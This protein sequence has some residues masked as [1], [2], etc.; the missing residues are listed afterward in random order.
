MQI[1]QM[2][3]DE[4]TPHPK[5]PRKHPEE[6]M[7]KLEES[8]YQ[9]GFNNPIL[10]SKDNMIIA[11]HARVLAAQ[12]LGMDEV[13]AIVLPLDGA[14]ADAYLI[15]DN[16]LCEMSQW[17][18]EL[19]LDMIDTIDAS[20]LDFKDVFFDA[21]EIDDLFNQI[22]TKDIVDD[23]FDV[24]QQLEDIVDPITQYGDIWRLGR[25]VLICGDSTELDTYDRLMGDERAVLVVTDPPYNINVEGGT[26]KK[27]KIQNDNMA[28]NDFYDFLLNFFKSTYEFMEDG[29]SIY[30]FH[31]DSEGMNFRMTLQE[32]GL[33]LSQVCIWVKNA[34]VL[35]RSDYHY[36]HEPILYGWKPTASHKWHSDRK[37]DTVWEYDSKNPNEPPNTVWRF[38]RPQRSEKHP[39][40]KPV[41]LIA[42]PIQNSSLNRAIVLDP[43]GGSGTT[44]IACEQTNRKCR[45]IEID[46]IYVDV[47]VNRYIEFMKTDKDVT[48]IRNEKEIPY[49][50]V[51]KE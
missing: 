31:A 11:G 20:G 37:Q 38:D 24:E 1:V 3:I 16:K 44:L 50:D 28:A 5:N 51:M 19:L 2:K 45:M 33:Y 26:S 47:I 21:A 48:L 35:S 4:L 18:A 27:L 14:K 15:L 43:F 42:Y 6:M 10:I 22:H 25:H 32:A 49:K 12:R 8:I 36:R 29:A 39:T 17:D 46:P 34:F 23:N 41:P 7:K 13:P 30:V 9:F 40:M